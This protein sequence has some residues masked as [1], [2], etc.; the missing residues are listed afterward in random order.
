MIRKI[1]KKLSWFIL[2]LL[3]NAVLFFIEV[4][5]LFTTNDGFTGGSGFESVDDVLEALN[6]VFNILEGMVLV[7]YL[8]TAIVLAIVALLLFIPVQVYYINRKFKN[9]RKKFLYSLLASFAVVMTLKLLLY[10]WMFIDL[11][12]L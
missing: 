2:Y 7:F 3:F 6:V 12:Y 11:N 5:V 1:L 10:A 9:H 8:Y 4:S